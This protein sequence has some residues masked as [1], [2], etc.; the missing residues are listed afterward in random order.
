MTPDVVQQV[1]DVQIPSLILGDGAFPLRIFM[2]KPHRYAMLPDDERYFNYR[3][4]R[5][6]PVTEGAFE[7][8]KIRFRVLF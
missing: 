5:A 2:L 6:R 4:S 7:R 1:G 8:L 3:N